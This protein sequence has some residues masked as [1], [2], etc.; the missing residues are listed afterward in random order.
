MTKGLKKLLIVDDSEIDR[1]ILK[2][3]LGDEF[4][5]TEATDGYLALEVILKNAKELDAILLD[6]SMPMLDGFSVLRVMRENHIDNI[7]VFLITAEATKDN[8]EKASQFNISECIVK[9]FEREE[10]LRRLKTRLGIMEAPE[11]K[12]EDLAETRSH[13]VHFTEVY[14]KYLENMGRDSRHYTRMTQLMKILLKRYAAEEKGNALS[15]DEID[16]ISRAAFF[17]DVGEMLLPA[18][19]AQGQEESE[20]Y[21]EHTALGAELVRLNTSSHCAFFVHVCAEMCLY[22]HERFDGAGFPHKISGD[23]IPVY[24]Q[25]CRAVDEFD[26]LLY[27]YRQYNELPFGFVL[28]EMERDKG[29]LSP[30]VI[31]LLSGSV[32][33]IVSAYK[34]QKAE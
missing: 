1:E 25:M 29:A 20:G 18:A 8:V 13:I 4:E 28:G 16:I 7:P 26:R 2:N 6:L 24:S 5:L 32:L 21:S 23:S 12:Q 10:I 34:A 27:K 22:H 14:K 15:K 30:E 31:S 17:C 3:I 19:D 33:N 11:L 9:P